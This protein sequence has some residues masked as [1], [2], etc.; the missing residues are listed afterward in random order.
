MRRT[1]SL[2]IYSEAKDNNLANVDHLF[3][4][5]KKCKI[6][7]GIVNQVN[8]YTINIAEED[9]LANFQTINYIFLI[10]ILK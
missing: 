1:A 8:D 10:L 5:N 4:I 7:L 2:S 6:E 9:Q 3:S